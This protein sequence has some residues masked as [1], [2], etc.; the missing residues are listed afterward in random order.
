MV[1]Q[2]PLLPPD[3]VPCLVDWLVPLRNPFVRSRHIL[4]VPD[5]LKLRNCPRSLHRLLRENSL[6]LPPCDLSVHVSIFLVQVLLYAQKALK[7]GNPIKQTRL[8]ISEAFAA[9]QIRLHP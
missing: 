1:T 7:R 6:N 9:S 8:L 4:A 3:P 2:C 5:H